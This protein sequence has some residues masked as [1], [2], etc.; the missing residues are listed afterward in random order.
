MKDKKETYFICPICKEPVEIGEWGELDSQ[1]VE[2]RLQN[3]RY[4]MV[5]H[6]K[7]KLKIRRLARTA[8]VDGTG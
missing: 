8:L 2:Y 5:C 1:G 7:E 3:K 6:H 4:H